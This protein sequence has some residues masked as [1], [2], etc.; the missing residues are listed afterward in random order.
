MSDQIALMRSGSI[1]QLGHPR[2]VYLRPGSAFAAD[3]MGRSN[4]IAGVVGPRSS[5]TTAAV[6]TCLGELRCALPDGTGSGAE[7]LVVIRPQA[8]IASLVRGETARENSFQGRIERLYF[9]GDFV[10]AEV[11]IGD[12]ML[13]VMLDVYLQANAGQTIWLELP[14]DRCVVVER[15]DDAAGL[16]VTGSA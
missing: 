4:L 5:A 7:V 10:E 3:F 15:T 8:I 2:D 14:A 1:V 9:L 16:A 11:R 12:A 13:R 6:N